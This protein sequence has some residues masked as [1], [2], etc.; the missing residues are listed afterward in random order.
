MKSDSCSHRPVIAGIAFS[1]LICILFSSY[2]FASDEPDRAVFEDHHQ[3]EQ[4]NDR[5]D[6]SVAV[7][8]MKGPVYMSEE[9]MEFYFMG[10]RFGYSNA[11]AEIWMACSLDAIEQFQ[12]S[13][14]RSQEDDA[15]TAKSRSRMGAEA[16]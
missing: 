5:D 7:Q 3:N 10:T 14:P 11:Q 15:F 4:W 16:R 8:T 12:K 13:R 1:L 6:G 9:Q 2:L